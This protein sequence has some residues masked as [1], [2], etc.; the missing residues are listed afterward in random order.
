M[1]IRTYL[2]HQLFLPKYADTDADVGKDDAFYCC[3]ATS[4]M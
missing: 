3:N 2:Y 1:Y 4:F